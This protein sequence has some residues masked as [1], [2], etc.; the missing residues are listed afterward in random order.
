M[1]QG[2][3]FRIVD[4]RTDR[5]WD[6]E[7]I[8]PRLQRRPEF[9]D[10]LGEPCDGAIAES[11]SDQRGDARQSEIYRQSVGS[12]RL[13]SFGRSSEAEHPAVNRT[14][15]GSSPPA[16]AFSGSRLDGKPPAL[17]AGESE[18]DSRDPDLK[19]GTR[20]CW[21]HA[22]PANPTDGFETHSLHHSAAVAE[23]SRRESPKL[24]DAGSSPAGS[25]VRA[26]VAQRKSDTRGEGLMRVQ[27]SSRAPSLWQK[28]EG[29]RQKAEG[30]RQKAEGRRQKAEGRRQKAEGR[31]RKAEGG[32]RK[33]EGRRQKAEGKRQKAEGRR[34]KAEGGRRKA[35]GG[36]RKAEGRIRFLTLPSAY[37]FLPSA[38][39]L[40]SPACSFS[41]QTAPSSKYSFFQIGTIFFKRSIA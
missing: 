34:R 11:V 33:A 16:R 10:S 8:H 3:R 20:C 40:L 35:E 12:G 4:L 30:G 17:G 23:R 7:A 36:R 29:G 14:C 13:S 18:F 15:G 24:V 32:R 41:T 19:M 9:G 22:G 21:R 27:V 38:Y 28:A 39:C 2:A 6:V 31:R 26:R 1:K 25:L 37:C 5:R